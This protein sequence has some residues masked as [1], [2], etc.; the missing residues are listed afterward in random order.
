[1][2]Q[3]WYAGH[4][5]AALLMRPEQDIF[6]DLM[7]LCTSPGYVH[8]IAYFYLRDNMIFYKDEMTAEDM[9][10]L[11]S[12]RCLIR[13]ETSTL[14]GLLIKKS[15]DYGQPAPAILQRYIDR[16]E[17]LLEELHRS[18]AESIF[19]GMNRRQA[20]EEGFN[21]FSQGRALR[22]PIFYSGESAYVFQYR[23]LLPRKYAAD[24]QWLKANK[25]FTIE[26][27]RDVVHALG[28]F[29]TK[30]L[31]DVVNALRRLPPDK[32][33]ALPGF[34]FTLEEASRISGA[35][36]DVVERVLAAFTLPK[37]EENQNFRCLHDFNVVNSMPLLRANDGTFILF[38]HYGLAEALYETPFYWMTSD[39]DYV[40]S[41]M[42]HRG[43][44]AE[45]FA[46]ERLERVFGKD[47]VHSN[48][49]IYESKGRKAGEIDVL[50][51]FGNR[52]IVLQAKSKRLTIEARR[53]NDRQIK[54]DFRRSVQDS[55]DQ[56]CKCAKLLGN[57]KYKLIAADSREIAIKRTLKEI[58]ILCV[59]SDCYP[60]LN[61]QA[62]QLL[63]FEE[64]EAIQPPL[65]TDIF[66]LDAMT[67]MLESPLH[68]LSYVNRRTGY[69]G[70]LMARDEMTIL[71]HHLKRNLWI[72][73][74]YSMFALDDSVSV[75]L[76]VAMT[77]RRDNVAGKR[78]PDGV[79][80]RITETVLGRIV[81]DI[82]AR[83]DSRTIDLGFMLLRLSEHAVI[84][85]SKGIDA[86][87]SKARQDGKSHDITALLGEAGTG[88]TVHCNDEPFP[89]AVRRLQNHCQ[90]RKYTQKASSWF[91]VCLSPGDTSVRFGCSLDYEWQPNVEMDVLTRDLPKTRTLADAVASVERKSKVGRNEPCP[92]GS[93]LKYKKCCLK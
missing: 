49:N 76:D 34:V 69:Y 52:A 63:K 73:D 30:R 32:W 42:M 2:P 55:Y 29:L 10:P 91:G 35:E 86:I 68:F 75:D 14:I 77:V 45:E 36:Q 41:A 59:V 54:E 47:H 19:A 80:T 74:E 89:T 13:T 85:M 43:Q 64:T 21:P 26:N 88:L 78:T 72:E 37:G 60:A 11:F 51:L 24:N 8:A 28:K 22:E 48:V 20:I 79:L 82:E 12:K 16:T 17:S 93:G 7:T 23:D 58:Y 5:S 15:I 66:A 84:Q 46:T 57:P 70:K 33:T 81:K 39:K 61:F 53:G 56:G 6:D 3:D 67:E 65:I 9:E 87:A 27:A 4:F 38:G 71:S 62:R 18:I 40:D 44:F 25:G 31:S 90:A 92:C 1:M 83:P 50:V